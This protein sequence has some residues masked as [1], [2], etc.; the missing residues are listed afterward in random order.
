MDAAARSLNSLDL[1]SLGKDSAAER[2]DAAACRIELHLIT[3]RRAFDALEAEW[4]DLFARTGRPTHV[5][6]SFNIC[7]H[8]ANHYL[9]SSSSGAPTL[10][11]S[12]V[13]GRRNG[14]LVMVWP[15]VSEHVRGV[16]QTF[17]MGSPV[18]QYGDVLLDREIDAQPAMHE[19]LNFLR[20]RTKS[21]LLRLRRVRSDANVAP[22]MDAIGAQVTDRQLAP[23]MDLASAKDFAHFE[24][25]YSGK[26]RKN[27][28]R[29]ARR[30]KKK[31]RWN[32]CVSAAAMKRVRWR[33]RR[34]SSRHSGS[35]TAA[36]FRTPSPTRECRVFSPISQRAN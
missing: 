11:L 28:R 13:T 16:T 21:D 27:R 30:S 2:S 12:I 9:S 36:W 35:K 15:L 6:Q 24:Q 14:R 26:T 5:F 23:Y 1:Q 10:K 32:L 33:S 34:S 8:W 4:N 17:W 7:W 3:E 19:A 18:G 29:L 25:H 22:L 20:A 31:A